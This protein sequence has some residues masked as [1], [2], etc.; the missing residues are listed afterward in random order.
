MQIACFFV[1]LYG[2]VQIDSDAVVGDPLKGQSARLIPFSIAIT[3]Y[4]GH[5]HALAFLIVFAQIDLD[6]SCGLLGSKFDGCFSKNS[7]GAVGKINRESIVRNVNGALGFG[8]PRQAKQADQKGISHASILRGIL[9]NSSTT[10][11]R[12]RMRNPIRSWLMPSLSW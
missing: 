9:F 12:S 3:T 10:P 11:S 4:L 1:F 6:R 8:K 7:V 5:L 2:F